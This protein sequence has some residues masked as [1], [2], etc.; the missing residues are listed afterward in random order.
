MAALCLRQ[1]LHR[2]AKPDPESV[3]LIKKIPEEKVDRRFEKE[4]TDGV[5]LL[6]TKSF[7]GD[8]ND[9]L[10]APPASWQDFSVKGK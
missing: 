7:L 9:G 2:T 1:V 3:G 6:L 10:S 5:Q 8:R 4:P